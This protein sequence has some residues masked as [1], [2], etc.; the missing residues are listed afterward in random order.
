[1]KLVDAEKMRSIDRRA[2]RACGVKGIV[3]M[4]NAGRTVADVVE[5]E[6]GCCSGTLSRVAV[7]AGKGNNG[8]DGFVAARHL[9]NRGIDVSVLAMAAPSDMKGDAGTNARIWEG[10]DG[11]TLLIGSGRDL[12]RHATVLKHSAVIVDALF[13]TGLSTDVRGLYADMI[14]LINSLKKRVV[15]VDIPSGIDATT[16]RVL[17]CAVRASVTVTMALPKLGH[18]LYPGRSCSGRVVVADIGM[19]RLLLEDESIKTNLTDDEFL[20]NTL[21]PREEDTHKGTYG[22]LLVVGGST[23]KSGA[24]YMAAMGALRSGAGL[25]TIGLPKG[26]NPS[27]ETK[28]TE[29]MTLPLPETPEGGLSEGALE[30]IKDFL[31]DKEALVLGP[32]IGTS[33]ETARFVIGLLQDLN[34]PS[35]ID[36]DGLNVLRGSLSVIKGAGLP[37]VLTPHPGEMARLLDV[38]TAHVQR[39]RIGSARRLSE[40]T[41]AVIVLKGASTVITEP[42]GTVYINPT[43]NPGLATAGTG[44]VLSGMIGGLMAQG[45]DPFSSAVSAV[46]MHGLAADRIKAERGAIGMAATDLLEKIPEIINRYTDPER[47]F[48]G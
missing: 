37:V 42:E 22:H 15:A 20:F 1:M 12:K 45:L 5:E 9:K 25:V 23:G 32:G 29:V 40:S 30:V 17:G 44:D 11:E 38:S 19:P 6:L 47:G 41:G 33:K 10:M 2:I 36:A 14:E 4:E 26:L 27:M 16:G 48:S 28:T 35:V 31:K 43:G 46:Y 13:G 18:Y 3:L 24:P 7:V 34:V 39:D 8:G 21:R